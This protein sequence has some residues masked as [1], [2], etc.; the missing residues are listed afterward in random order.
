MPRRS[1][2]RD[3]RGRTSPYWVSGPG[4]G[5][6]VE[7][8]KRREELDSWTPALP[9]L[10]LPSGGGR[11]VLKILEICSGCGSVSAATADAARELGVDDV[12]VFSV[13]GKPGTHATRTV[14]ILTY[15]W[16]SDED[17]LRFMVPEGTCIFYAHASPPCGPY[18]SMA[19]RYRGGLAARDLRWGDSVAQR[20][21]DLHRLLPPALLDHRIAGAA[22]PGLPALHA[23]PGAAALHGELLP[24]RNAAV[25]GNQH[26][27]QP[28]DLETRAALHPQRPVRSLPRARRSP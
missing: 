26:L 8:M 4:E 12:Q 27:D 15:D 19:A 13:D 11:V 20:C 3:T 5:V 2:H 23:K 7:G 9:A 10:R 24:L 6:V 18:S 28:R 17:L 22:R 16:A 1:D 21:L 14:D 25:E